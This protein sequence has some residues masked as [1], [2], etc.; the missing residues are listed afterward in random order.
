MTAF[1]GWEAQTVAQLNAQGVKV[2]LT[3]N[4]VK[5]LDQWQAAEGN[6]GANNPLN[7]TQT[8]FPSSGTVADTPGVQNYTT[9]QAGAAATAAT[10]KQYPSIVTA[11]QSG[12]PYN[13]NYAPALTTSFYTWTHGPNNMPTGTTAQ[14]NNLS[15]AYQGIVTA[16]NGGK[17]PTGFEPA[18]P[19]APGTFGISSSSG[20]GIGRVV[21]AGKSVESSAQSVTGF[22][23]DL[24]NTSYLLRGLE[25]IGGAILAF[26]GLLLLAR[27]IGFSAPSI[28]VASTAAEA[29]G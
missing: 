26:A 11:L 20:L 17:P 13:P 18:Q 7:T 29:V 6:G 21:R 14:F 1:Q 28:P 27:Q 3:A 24:T 25:V 10:I 16:A 12:N 23:G 19:S 15:Q 8:G 4:V 5:F 9:P 22:L 2:P